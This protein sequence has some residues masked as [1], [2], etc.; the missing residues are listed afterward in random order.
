MDTTEGILKPSGVYI[1]TPRASV[2]NPR[3]WRCIMA[4]EAWAANRQIRF[5]FNEVVDKNSV[6]QNHNSM[7]EHF[8]GRTYEWML[9]LDSDA[10]IPPMALERMLSWDKEIVVP[11]MFRNVPPYSPTIYR[12]RIGPSENRSW[13]QDFRW[14]EKWCR[15]HLNQLTEH[16]EPAMLSEAVE[17]PLVKVKRSGTHV[18]LVH[19]KVLENT[20]PPWFVAKKPSGSGSDFLFCGKALEAGF[21]IWCDLSIFSG[22]LQGDYCAGVVDWLVW[23][24][25]THYRDDAE[26]MRIRVQE[27]G[28]ELGNGE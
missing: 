6:A 8:L 9:M 15:T 10:V 3:Y 11:L 4:L 22:H 28:E 26:G 7:I 21:D 27:V 5:S 25:V 18:M 20:S 23:N 17:D 13:K 2:P 1:G 24:S 16:D 14:I 19:R 12:E